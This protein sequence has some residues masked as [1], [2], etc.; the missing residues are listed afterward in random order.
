MK[1]EVSLKYT[2]YQII[3]VEVP[4]NTEFDEEALAEMAMDKFDYEY[5][6]GKLEL[7]YTT[8]IF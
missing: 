2:E 3:E 6:D 4:D 1:Y 8:E 7:E 5:Q